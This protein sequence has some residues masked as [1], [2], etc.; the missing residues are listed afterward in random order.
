MF[1]YSISDAGLN[2]IKKN[3]GFVG[4]MYRDGG[5]Y[6]IGYGHQ[7]NSDEESYYRGKVISKAEASELLVKDIQKRAFQ[8]NNIYAPGFSL[9]QN[10][11]DMIMDWSM[12]Q[13]E[14]G[15]TDSKLFEL[16]IGGATQKE[17]SD[18]WLTHYTTS[19]GVPSDALKARRAKEVEIFFSPLYNSLA[20]NEFFYSNPILVPMVYIGLA[21]LGFIVLW[22]LFG[23][24]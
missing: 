24:S 4:T 6:S 9:S 21:F 14:V 2:F 20:R 13:D 17:I 16:L 15:L 10:Q 12:S 23:K 7:L 5:R 22:K 11:F 1:N 8:I 18:W 3:E 19:Q